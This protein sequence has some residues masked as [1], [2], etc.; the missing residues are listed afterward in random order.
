MSVPS[1]CITQSKWHNPNYFSLQVTT[2]GWCLSPLQTLAKNDL[3]IPCWCWQG[4]DLCYLRGRGPPPQCLVRAFPR[5]PPWISATPGAAAGHSDLPRSR[6]KAACKNQMEWPWNV[7]RAAVGSKWLEAQDQRID[8][9]LQPSSG[10][11]IPARQGLQ[12]PR[13]RTSIRGTPGAEGLE[14]SPSCFVA[15]P[16]MGSSQLPLDH[17]WA[18]GC[19]LPRFRCWFRRVLVLGHL[20][21]S[22]LN[23]W[24]NLPFQ[25]FPNFIHQNSQL[26]LVPEHM[27][28]LQPCRIPGDGVSSQFMMGATRSRLFQSWSTWRKPSQQVRSE[29]RNSC[30]SWIPS[31]VYIDN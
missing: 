2:P 8:S 4:G 14:F 23:Q 21:V 20:L 24:S 30:W 31:E 3:L 12:A 22:L 27:G 28:T 5:S 11:E 9:I 1:L 17:L 6:T 25:E 15:I 26:L 19:L 7:S 16:L 29:L 13:Q 10:C 18:L